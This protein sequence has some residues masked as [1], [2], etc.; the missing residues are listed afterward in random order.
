[1][2]NKEQIFNKKFLNF[3]TQK[4]MEDI[5]G[6]STAISDNS[7]VV[8]TKNYFFELSVS[9]KNIE[10]FCYADEKERYIDKDEFMTLYKSST[11]QNMKHICIEGR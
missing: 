1:M 8:D 11:T 9:D 6:D 7:I 4:E 3:F 5:V 2:D 10:I